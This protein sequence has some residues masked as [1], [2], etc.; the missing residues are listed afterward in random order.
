MTADARYGTAHYDLLLA[1]LFLSP[2]LLEQAAK[3]LTASHFT[4]RRIGG[5]TAQALLF[6]TLKNH[7]DTYNTAPDRMAVFADLATQLSKHYKPG[8][9]IL[10]EIFLHIGNFF[11]VVIKWATKDSLMLARTIMQHIVKTCIVDDQSNALVDEAKANNNLTGLGKRLEEIES[12]FSY[13]Q[14][15]LSTTGFGPEVDTPEDSGGRILTGCSFIDSRLGMGHGPTTACAMAI[16]AGQ[17]SGKTTLGIQMACEQV[18]MG[19]HTLLVLVESGMVATV[20]RNLKACLTGISTIYLEQTLG[21]IGEAAKLAGFTPEQIELAYQKIKLSDQ[22]CHIFDCNKYGGAALNAIKAEVAQL[23]A[24]GRK[25]EIVY[26]DWAGLVAN[27]MLAASEPHKFEKLE[28]ALKYF[29]DQIADMAGKHNLLAVASHQMAAAEYKRGAFALTDQYSGQDARG[30]TQSMSYVI[31]INQKDPKAPINEAK[32]AMRIVKSRNDPP[33]SFVVRHMGPLQRF[34]EE[35]G[36]TMHGK[37]FLRSEGRQL[38]AL[39]V[40]NQRAA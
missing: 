4:D 1:H 24:S 27:R 5:T 37:H 9:P 13:L 31:V 19:H 25:P 12:K 35:V 17:G 36:W 33:Q 2:L 7:Y 16:I 26:I 30:F 8:D 32:Q 28:P 23:D 18:L 39:P 22:Y 29:G 38:N 3:N 40:E 34:T 15:G 11:D 6:N 14:G 20:R 10:V 21:H